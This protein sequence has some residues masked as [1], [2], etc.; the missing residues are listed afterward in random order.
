[1]KVRKF[2]FIVACACPSVLT[3]HVSRCQMS[4]YLG[5][6]ANGH[7]APFEAETTKESIKTERERGKCLCICIQAKVLSLD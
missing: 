5:G 2:G 6:K 1:M 4:G 7:P 3:L